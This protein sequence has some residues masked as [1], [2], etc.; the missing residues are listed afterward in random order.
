MSDELPAGPRTGGVLVRF[1]GAQG[2]GR[3]AVSAFVAGVAGTAAFVGSLVLDWQKV[4]VPQSG[5]ARVSAT[6]EFTIG[7]DA[8]SYSLVFLL[9]VLGLITLLGAVVARPVQAAR[10]RMGAAGLGLGL[11]GMVVAIVFQMRDSVRERYVGVVIYGELPEEIQQV[12]DDTTFG[13]MPGAFLGLGTVVVLVAG[14]WLAARGA[15]GTELAGTTLAGAVP[16]YV[17]VPNLPTLSPGDGLAA[18]VVTP[19]QPAEAA[20]PLSLAPVSSAAANPVSAAPAEDSAPEGPPGLPP[21]RGG[22][23]PSRPSGR[24]GYADGLTVTPAE[25]MDQGTR[26]DILRN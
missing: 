16:G 9:G 26:P 8:A 12:L 22:A 15:P 23:G 25:P 14:V 3:S 4:T 21:D 20:V 6:D 18:F 19:V 11:A 10:L 7:L 2:G 5:G 17:L 13:L 1:L 24:V